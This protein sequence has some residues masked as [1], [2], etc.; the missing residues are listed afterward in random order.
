MRRTLILLAI[1]SMAVATQS[2]ARGTHGKRGHRGDDHKARIAAALELT[3]EQLA[4]IEAL[5]AEHKAEREA[6]REAGRTAFEKI[7]TAEQLDL[8]SAYRESR[9][10]G[11]RRKRGRP[12]L[13]LTDEQKRQLQELRGQRKEAAQALRAG[14][15]AGFEAILT[16]EQIATLEK[17]KSRRKDRRRG[18]D[19]ARDDAGP[20]AAPAIQF[21]DL[22]DDGAPTV[23]GDTS[24]GLI[25]EQLDR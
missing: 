3:E 24:W 10:A 17:L 15:R 20:D 11:D 2:E 21:M 14:F 7:L 6:A 5:K 8:L 23:I 16:A 25:K 12:D 1:L 9:K 18:G 22:A 13:E 4:Q 19:K